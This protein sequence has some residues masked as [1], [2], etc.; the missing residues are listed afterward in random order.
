LTVFRGWILII[1]FLISSVR[2]CGCLDPRLGK[3]IIPNTGILEEWNNGLMN[4]I[5]AQDPS[6]FQYSTIP[7]K[8]VV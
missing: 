3:T 8:K 1:F 6:S 4:G 2:D 5:G 7:V